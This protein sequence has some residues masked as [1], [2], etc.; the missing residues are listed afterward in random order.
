MITGEPMPV[1]KEAGDS[2]VAGTINTNG[3]FVF[4][5]TKVGSE[6]M[7]AHIVKMVEGAQ[8]SRAPIQALAD[9]ISGVFVPIVLVIAFVALGAWL[10]IGTQILG[11]SQA[12]SFGLV[13]FVGI[14]VIACPC[15]LGLATPTA[16]IVGVGKGAREGI[17]VKDAATLEKLH[18]VNVVVMDKTGTITK[19]KPELVSLNNLSLNQDSS[20]GRA[21]LHGGISQKSDAEII[22]ILASLENKSEHPIAHAV[23]SYAKEKNI[24]LLSV[25]KF[26]MVKG[27]G[28]TGVVGGV[29]YRVGSA[30]FAGEFGAS[31][32]RSDLENSGLRSDLGMQLEKDTVEGKT[33]V[34]LV[35]GNTV[36]AVAMI[37]HHIKPKTPSIL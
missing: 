6:T 21:S 33:P 18:K 27:K 4:K 19:G 2:V 26:E 14:L 22:A 8:G 9:K 37:S 13:S 12:L 20:L 31:I 35:A 32:P 11:F 7:L 34:I 5:A 10:A 28:I 16:I 24:T 15:A 29:E 36:L 1:K 30:K 3:S 17:L 23:V 25:E